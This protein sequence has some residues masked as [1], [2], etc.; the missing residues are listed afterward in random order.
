MSKFNSISEAQEFMSTKVDVPV[1][2]ESYSLG[3]GGS[4]FSSFT[5]A[6]DDAR[7]TNVYDV[8]FR[9]DKATPRIHTYD[10]PTDLYDFAHSSSVN[11]VTGAVSFISPIYRVEPQ[12]NTH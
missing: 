5:Q 12:D 8:S 4:S 9:A 11:V 1:G 2:E 6:L 3:S 7:F 10:Q